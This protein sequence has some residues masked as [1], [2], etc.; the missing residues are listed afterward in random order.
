[1]CF[2]F[3]PQ[4]L[5]LLVIYYLQVCNS[6]RPKMW[7]REEIEEIM[8]TA[9][10]KDTTIADMQAEIIALNRTVSILKD[11]ALTEFYSVSYEVLKR[12]LDEDKDYSAEVRLFRYARVSKIATAA[13]RFSLTTNQFRVEAD[14]VLNIRHEKVHVKL[15]VTRAQLK[16]LAKEKARQLFALYGARVTQDLAFLYLTLLYVDDL[17]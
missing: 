15:A 7:T 1:M 8:S 16:N 10:K 13:A 14:G 3:D 4:F 11:L 12:M 9:I 17:I 5:T 6:E 2:V